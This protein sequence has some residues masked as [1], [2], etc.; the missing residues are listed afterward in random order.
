MPIINGKQTAALIAFSATLAFPC[1]ELFHFER[2]ILTKWISNFLCLVVILALACFLLNRTLFNE[3]SQ[4]AVPVYDNGSSVSAVD[5]GQATE[6][7]QVVRIIEARLRIAVSLAL[8][9]LLP[10]FFILDLHDSIKS[11]ENNRFLYNDTG[12]ANGQRLFRSITLILVA[13]LFRIFLFG[14]FAFLGLEAAN[15]LSIYASSIT[16]LTHS[17]DFAPLSTI[18]DKLFF[19][20]G[21]PLL[22]GDLCKGGCFESRLFV[23]AFVTARF[24]IVTF[25]FGAIFNVVGKLERRAKR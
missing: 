17:D 1:R 18:Q 11:S 12:L 14:I 8:M 5:V 23:V 9:V 6:P 4:K 7:F 3:V 15:V 19:V 22:P 13:Y 24:L 16:L 20:L 10:A 2:W 21:N 25:L